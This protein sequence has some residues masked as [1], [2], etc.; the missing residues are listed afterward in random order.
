MASLAA[1]PADDTVVRFLEGRLAGPER[2]EIT[3]HVDGCSRCSLL[4]AMPE[5]GT[6]GSPAERGAVS[7]VASFEPG[8]LLAGRYRITRLLGVGGMGEVYEAFDQSLGEAVA[9]K[10]VRATV[11]DH[12]RAVD[13][14]KSEVLLARR[15]THPNVCRIFDFGLHAPEGADQPLP[16]L[17]MELLTG[18]TLAA[19]IRERRPLAPAQMVDVARQ[20]AAGL[21]AAH[22]VEVI[23][24]DL[25]A[26]NV[27]LIE[28]TGEPLRAV[29]TDFGLAATR[30]LVEGGPVT[31]TFFSG[32]PGYVA[33]ERMAGT[34]V[35]EVT[36]VY[37]LGVV[38]MDML[39]GTLPTER[40]H[41]PITAAQAGG[42]DTAL[43]R[44]ARRCQD[45]D[46]RERPALPEVLRALE[47][48]Q[49]PAGSAP[50]RSPGRRATTV[51]VLALAVGIAFARSRTRPP[52]APPAPAARAT[53]VALAPPSPRAELAAPPAAGRAAPP[54]PRPVPPRP[55]R[56][57]PALAG[58]RAP[59]VDTLRGDPAADTLR[60]AEER[61]GAGRVG[62]ACALGQV[63]AGQAP[64][65]PA[66]WEFLGRCYMR[67]PDP[68][69]ARASYRKYLELAPDGPRASL[70][71]A[72][73]E[74]EGR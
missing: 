8:A 59:A 25:K 35:T 53:T 74:P 45:P 52:A 24:K 64:R 57:K 56:R 29:I 58:P 54:D 3:E 65:A 43:A 46:A 67:L 32:T 19:R 49:R 70:I 10:T 50:G 28:E 1:C 11:A 22:E 66:V 41:W 18:A 36:D 5:T 51:V 61:L 55:R 4:L 7:P 30:A 15:V 38:M 9:L 48:M 2:D 40:S 33:P 13:R 26:D 68:E 73:V 71:R 69:E 14:L 17:T 27:M 39:T 37:S 6:S 12:P 60:G 63:A 44:L 72:I 23:H 62:E 47:A 16:F 20:V 21:H 31:A 42:S 34:P